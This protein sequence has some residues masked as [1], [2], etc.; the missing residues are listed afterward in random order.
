M[1]SINLVYIWNTISESYVRDIAYSELFRETFFTM[2]YYSCT[3]SSTKNSCNFFYSHFKDCLPEDYIKQL[4]E[5]KRKN[6]LKRTF[7]YMRNLDDYVVAHQQHAFN[8][9]LLE[10]KV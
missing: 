10:S 1:S 6:Y 4:Y 3:N 8:E 5:A 2:E 9:I 7:N